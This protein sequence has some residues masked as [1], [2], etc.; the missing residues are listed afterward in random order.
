[1]NEKITWK[2]TIAN[3]EN[4]P[5]EVVEKLEVLRDFMAHKNGA[6][7]RKFTKIEREVTK[8]LLTANQESPMALDRAF[9]KILNE[10]VFE[11]A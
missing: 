6:V 7:S 3:P 1:M 5:D 4:I 8:K 2:T 10:Y 9:K 11:A